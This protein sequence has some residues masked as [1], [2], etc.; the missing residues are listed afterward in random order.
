[1]E[2]EPS[3]LIIS[4]YSK[5]PRTA[6]NL[7][8]VTGVAIAHVLTGIT[9]RVDDGKSQHTSKAKALKE[10]ARRVNNLKGKPVEAKQQ[11]TMDELV[12]IN[13][14]T[15]KMLTEFPNESLGK[16]SEVMQFCYEALHENA[17]L[18]A[19]I[20]TLEAENSILSDIVDEYQPE[21][22]DEAND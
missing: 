15:K 22:S 3:Y 19:R 7:T 1:V 8:P 14:I 9:V 20:E 11:D 13:D 21:E 4:L 6:W 10:L 5:K 2:F 17:K 12:A 16:L 18:K